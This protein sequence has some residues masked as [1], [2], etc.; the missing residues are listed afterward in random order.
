M[1]AL[2]RDDR[3]TARHVGMYNAILQLWYKGKF[4]NPV[5]ITRRTLLPLTNIGSIVTYHKCIRE[6]EQFGYIRYEPSN[7]PA[8]GSLVYL[9]I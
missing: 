3:I 7:H 8:K 6:L 1:A 2:S 9:N 4:C 5:C